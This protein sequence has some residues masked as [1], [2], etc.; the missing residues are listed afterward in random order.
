MGE[1]ARGPAEARTHVEHR[2]ARADGGAAR[3]RLHRAEPTVVILIPRPEIFRAQIADT[4]RVSMRGLEDLGL[5]DGVTI[6]EVD[7][8][9]AGL[10]HR[11]SV[12]R[13]AP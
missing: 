6:I 7:D 5:V 1:E 11:G 9:D 4:M 13:S 12:R 10:A 8:R 2:H 3:E